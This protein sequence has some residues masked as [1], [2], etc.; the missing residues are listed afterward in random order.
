MVAA[1]VWHVK[2]RKSHST[3]VRVESLCVRPSNRGG[4]YPASIRCKS[5]RADILKVVFLKEEDSHQMMAT[6]ETPAQHI[7]SRG[8]PANAVQTTT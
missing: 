1:M 5:L 4:V 6:E 8:E 2:Y 3:K 7:R